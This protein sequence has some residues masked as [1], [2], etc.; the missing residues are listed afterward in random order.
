VRRFI[1]FCASYGAPRGFAAREIDLTAAV[2]RVTNMYNIMINKLYFFP[3][4]YNRIFGYGKS[5][6]RHALVSGFTYK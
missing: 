2:S 5:R 6:E 4:R 3:H 1:R